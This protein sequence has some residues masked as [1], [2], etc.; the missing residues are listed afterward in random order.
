MERKLIPER[1]R[2]WFED[3]FPRQEQLPSPLEVFEARQAAAK[4]AALQARIGYAERIRPFTG[5]LLLITDLGPDW[6]PGFQAAK[7]KNA[8]R[9]IRSGIF[10]PDTPLGVS[11]H[12]TYSGTSEGHKWRGQSTELLRDSLQADGFANILPNE[13]WWSDQEGWLQRVALAAEATAQTY[14]AA[15]EPERVGHIAVVHALDAQEEMNASPD[16][17]QGEAFLLTGISDTARFAWQRFDIPGPPKPA[18]D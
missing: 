9:I 4:A 17:T 5:R 15:A 10:A 14:Q 8:A 7:A 1:V 11:V 18:T 6:M 13:Y 16:F 2:K 3:K 12:Y